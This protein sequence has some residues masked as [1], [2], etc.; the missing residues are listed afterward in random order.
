MTTPLPRREDVPDEKKWSVETVFTST[1]VWEAEF[2]RVNAE[3]AGFAVFAG[4]L[5]ASPA[6]LYAAL[7]RLDDIGQAVYKVGLYASMLRA[8]DSGNQIAVAL[9]SRAHGLYSR[10]A[11]ATAFYEPE[12]LALPPERL[13]GWAREDAGL[14]VYRHYFDTLALRRAHVRSEEVE[15][16]LAQVSEPLAALHTAANSLTDAD[17][18]FKP[19]TDA[20][21]EALE[22]AQGTISDLLRH[23][24]ADLRRRAWESYAD[25]YLSVKNT[26]AACLS[27]QVKKTVFTAR[28]RRYPSALEAALAPN[29]IPREVFDT[30]L[31]TFQSNLPIWHRYWGLLRRGL[32]VT[33]LHC[34]DVP[35]DAVPAPI[36]RA[37]LACQLCTSDRLDL[38]GHG[39][40]GRGLCQRDAAR[41]GRAALGGCLAQQGQGQRGV[42]YGS[43]RHASVYHDELPG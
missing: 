13:D 10:F 19:V 24:S 40:A 18:T 33:R 8:G 32:G 17:L 36:P 6:M 23:P 39:P 5:G 37:E 20:G 2:A 15:S 11:A 16:L 25:G 35:A 28:T 31:T 12:L 43:A 42:L 3:I 14:A 27:G 29:A 41:P 1:E 9:S 22:V 7:S 26:L 38:P 30:L 21:G 34:A 4:H